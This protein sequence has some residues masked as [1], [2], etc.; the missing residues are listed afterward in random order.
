MKAALA[1]LTLSAAAI[2]FIAAVRARDAGDGQG[3]EL[4]NPHEGAGT[5]E[6]LAASA[7]AAMKGRT[8]RASEALKN[9]LKASESLRLEPYQLN[10]GGWTVGYGHWEKTR[11]ALPVL[12]SQADAEAL[13][14]KDLYE[15]GEKWVIAEINVELSQHEYDALVHIAYNMSPKSFRKFAAAVND[16]Q[17]IEAI[18]AQ[19]VDW[20]APEYKNGIRNRRN[21]EIAMFNQGIYA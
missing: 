4:D 15:R 9:K 21:R 3:S 17:G 5:I 2:A 6:D 8:F 7:S 19:S 10:D 11:S 14:E 20:V 1:M 13:F 12:N 16:G 18:A